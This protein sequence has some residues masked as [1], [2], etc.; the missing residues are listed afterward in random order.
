MIAL[1]RRLALLG[2]L[3]LLLPLQQ[4]VAAEHPLDVIVLLD[5]QPHRSPADRLFATNMDGTARVN[6]GVRA[7]LNACLLRNV[8][9]PDDL[10]S[11]NE[12]SWGYAN[13]AKRLTLQKRADLLDIEKSYATAGAPG[14][15]KALQQVLETAL[16]KQAPDLRVNLANCGGGPRGRTVGN[17][18]GYSNWE[19]DDLYEDLVAIPR[20]LLPYVQ[21]LPRYAKA[22]AGSYSKSLLISFDS[23]PAQAQ[24][25]V[26]ATQ[27]AADLETRY[28]HLAAS[29][30]RTQV[31]A[32]VRSARALPQFGGEISYC[33]TRDTEPALLLGYRSLGLDMLAPSLVE[34]INRSRSRINFGRNTTFESL[35]D[36]FVAITTGKQSCSVVV[37][38][39]KQVVDLRTALA[40]QRDSAQGAQFGA[41]LPLD[42][43][44]DRYARGLNQGY[45]NF[46]QLSFA[47]AI[48][49]GGAALAQLRTYGVHA[50]PDYQREAAAMQASGH[51]ADISATAVLTYLQDLKDGQQRGLGVL[52]QRDARLLQARREREQLDKSRREARAAYEKQYPYEAVISCGIEQR[53]Q[54]LVPCFMSD[55]LNSHIEIT[56]GPAYALYQPWELHKLGNETAGEGLVIALSN[57]FKLNMQNVDER[58]VLRLVIRE[59]AGGSVVY[60]K[61]AARFGVI[62]YSNGP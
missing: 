24:A 1:P 16:R 11:V 3:T 9:V 45:E 6:R 28:A 53:H 52:A 26:A 5:M 50:L 19:V 2:A 27:A 47:R 51:T 35:N 25:N 32:L 17:T 55:G 40:S 59:T 8:T 37:G 15:D 7:D 33:A 18:L 43:S 57:S 38:T 4:A 34:Q 23:L 42:E 48:G 56:N 49:G 46:A 41:L 60:E 13:L 22:A 36:I 30:D 58:L 61:A 62:R 10:K 21:D 29:D 54:A 31:A 44:R 39:A 12:Q 14:A 20:V